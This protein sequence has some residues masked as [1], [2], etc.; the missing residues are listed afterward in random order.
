MQNNTKGEFQDSSGSSFW[1][2]AFGLVVALGSVVSG[3]VFM[4][5]ASSPEEFGPKLTHTIKRGKL[6][7]SVTEQGTLESSDN[8]EIICQVRGNNTVNWVVE[9]GTWVEEGDPL[10]KLDTL[11]IDEEI[12]ERTKYAHWSRSG[13]LGSKAWMERS[14]LAIKEY[15]EGRFQAELLTLQKDLAI[16]QS[17][18]RTA[19]NM[20]AHSKLM[21]QRG[22]VSD[23]EI[24]RREFRV[25][26]SQL[27][28]E[29]K[30]TDIDVL[31]RFTKEEE[32]IRLR[33]EYAKASAQF[34]ASD[35]RAGA[36]ASR[37]DRAI[38][39]EKFCVLTAPK[40]GLVIHPSAARWRNAPEITE[41]GTVHKDQVL[42]LMPDMEKMQVNVGVHESIID[43]IE[44]GLRAWITLPGQVLEGKVAEVA[45]IT[46]PAGWW[47]GNVVKYDTIIELP[48][49][50]GLKPGMSAEVEVIIA[51]QSNVLLIPVAAVVETKTEHLCWVKTST[52]T[53]RR[54]LQL[55][56]SNDTFIEVK[57]GVLEGDQ[58]I[59]NPLS[60]VEEAQQEAIKD[61]DDANAADAQ[62]AAASD[63]ADKPTDKE[64][65]SKPAQKPKPNTG[66][67]AKTS[68]KPG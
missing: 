67:P 15:E 59:L 50:P 32:L 12:N 19:Q 35:E 56:D 34:E 27:A 22:Y 26:E 2:I 9:S 47:T 65:A 66:T 68:N 23:L 14:N 20:L 8:T 36:D 57:Q 44:P 46:R 41:G 11:F 16:S 7:V 53:E 6:V 63:Q 29:V 39:E 60:L 61:V 33:G 45:D 64:P 17:R 42:L 48:N 13:A 31:Q 54:V 52:G 43:S 24:E 51:V 1:K 58:V 49:V 3:A 5:G 10:L 25:I 30:E 37:R 62:D 55:G 18:L 28:V 40:T 21:A 4:L 38:A